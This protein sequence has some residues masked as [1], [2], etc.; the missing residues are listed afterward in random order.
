MKILIRADGAPEIGVGHLTRCLTLAVALKSNGHE[1]KFLMTDHSGNFS[2]IVTKDGFEVVF[3]SRGEGY[4]KPVTGKESTWL[5]NEL[6]YELIEANKVIE[7]YNPDLAIVDHYGLDA[8]WEK[9]IRKSVKSIFVIDDLANRAHDCDYLLDQTFGRTNLDYIKLVPAGCKFFLGSDYALLR[10]EFSR[11][12]PFRTSLKKIFV[13]FGGSDPRGI[14][15][16]IIQGIE[17]EQKTKMHI[18]VILREDSLGYEEVKNITQNSIHHYEHLSSTNKMA[19]LMASADLAFG[20]G[21][22]SAWE[23]CAVSLP[24]IGVQLADNQKLV[25]ENLSRKGALINIGDFQTVTPDVVYS[26]LRIILEN[27]S[28]LNAMSKASHEVC[29]GQG[30]DRV[31]AIFPPGKA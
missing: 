28:F 30:V 19:D 26:T 17:L 18:T 1:I 22:T 2:S 20:A 27:E 8:A 29:D 4:Q 9:E 6:S 10:P 16:K 5:G 23:R 24:A 14:T 15:L 11:S 12:V 3:V 31:A 21:G 13:S 7:K 25:L